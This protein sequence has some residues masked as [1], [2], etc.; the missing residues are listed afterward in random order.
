[1]RKFSDNHWAITE[2]L[3]RFL[4]AENSFRTLML[5]VV[6]S[7]QHSPKEV[8]NVLGE[9]FFEKIQIW[10]PKTTKNRSEKKLKP[11]K[12]DRRN[13]KKKSTQKFKKI[14]IQKSSIWKQ[15]DEESKPEMKRF[16]RRRRSWAGKK[17]EKE[18]EIL[19][20]MKRA[21]E[22]WLKKYKEKKT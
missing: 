10:N 3:G 8:S 2:T 19:P 13:P 1:M 20:K 14:V 11:I 21:D 6:I 15:S 7:I 12:S 18:R 17:K 22:K 4:T 16:R 9:N 5:K